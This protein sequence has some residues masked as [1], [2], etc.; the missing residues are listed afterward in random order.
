MLVLAPSRDAAGFLFDVVLHLDKHRLDLRPQ[1]SAV[2]LPQHMKLVRGDAVGFDGV[3]SFGK[4]WNEV[5][6]ILGGYSG[7]TQLLGSR[8]FNCEFGP[9]RNRSGVVQR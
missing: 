2:V 9:E 8:Q 4:E 6:D 5:P 3:T 7:T 1:L